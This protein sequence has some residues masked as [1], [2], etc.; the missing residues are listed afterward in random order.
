MNP[1]PL[2]L[3]VFQSVMTLERCNIIRDS[4]IVFKTNA[5]S[6]SLS[7][8]NGKLPTNTLQGSTNRFVP[9]RPAVLIRSKCFDNTLE[10]DAYGCFVLLPDPFVEFAVVVEEPEE[11]EEDDDFG[12][13]NRRCFC[14]SASAW[15]TM[16]VLC[17]L[18]EIDVDVEVEG[19]VVQALTPAKFCG[20]E[21][22]DDS[23]IIVKEIN[24]IIVNVAKSTIVDNTLTILT[25]DHL[26]FFL[27]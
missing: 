4:P 2:L 23:T 19:V 24:I 15:S 26:H 9:L 22:D 27:L 13:A 1:Y 8:S 14:R 5:A 11:E 17:R 20:C 21:V 7:A 3:P 16:I 6:W 25:G 12:C 18:L 10:S